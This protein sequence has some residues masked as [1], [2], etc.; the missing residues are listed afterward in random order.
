MQQSLTVSLC[1]L[2]AVL[3]ELSNLDAKDINVAEKQTHQLQSLLSI[4]LLGGVASEH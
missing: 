2:F 4:S 3:L 1:S